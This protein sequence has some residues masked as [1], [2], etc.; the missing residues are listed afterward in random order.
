MTQSLQDTQVF[1][2][3]GGLGTRIRSLFPD[4][5]KSL[6]PVHNRPF[7]EW[8]IELLI[9]QGFSHF[10]LCVSY[11]ADKIIQ[12]FRNGAAW[13][14]DIEYSIE[15]SP[16]GTAGA[17]KHAARFFEGTSLVLNGDTYLATDYRVLL[18]KHRQQTDIT[19]SLGLV[20]VQDTSRYGQVIITSDHHITEFREKSQSL[21]QTGLINAGVYV[22]EPRVLDYIPSGRAVSIEQETFPTLAAR[23]V[24]YGF[25]VAGP[26]V[27]MGTPEGY[28]SL[29]TLLK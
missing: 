2:L 6:I 10:V 3:A 4:R 5:P 25:P 23:N 24:L 9:Q 16:L 29:V 1:I 27:D 19:G 11:L 12:Y 28:E 17:I 26:F 18:A 13:G 22:L 7:L 20:T 15:E 21:S 14:V 8:Q